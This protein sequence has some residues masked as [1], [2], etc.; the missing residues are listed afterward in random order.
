MISLHQRIGEF[1]RYLEAERGASP[2]TRAAYRRDLT[3]FSKYL[4]TRL[5]DASPDDVDVMLVRGYLGELHGS[6]SSA[7]ISRKLSA[8]RSFYRF[9]NKRGL[10]SSDPVALLKSPKKRAPLPK[11]L[12]VDEALHLMELARP[13]DAPSLRDRAMLEVLY[14]GG[15][16]VS[17]LVGL[18]LDALDIEDG[19]ARVL[20]KG[21][22][23]R[24]VPL[25]RKAVEALRKYLDQRMELVPEGGVLRDT[26]AVFISRFGQRI[27]IRRV[28]QIVDEQAR[29]AGVRQRSSPHDLRHSCA[30]HLLDSGADL[31]SIQ[32]LLGHAS[33]NTTQRYTHV[34]VDTMMSVYDESHPHSRR[35]K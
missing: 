29:A 7:T 4:S 14:G 27:S 9:L 31:R 18:D 17:E 22:K 10:A 6:V 2:H 30:T 28:Q 3:G 5:P 12:P 33:L 25:G 24:I 35:R 23:E 26:T 1:D 34:T 11:F 20:G 32:E 16:R 19:L 21:N 13:D 15:L 8:L